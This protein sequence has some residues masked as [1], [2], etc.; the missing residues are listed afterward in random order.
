MYTPGKD[1]AGEAAIGRM[2]AS[3]TRVRTNDALLSTSL[4]PLREQ[5]RDATDRADRLGCHYADIEDAQN[6]RG[7]DDS[8]YAPL[9]ALD[10]DEVK[11]EQLKEQYSSNTLASAIGEAP[12]RCFEDL[13][14]KLD[15]FLETSGDIFTWLSDDQHN[16]I[17]ELVWE[18]GRLLPDFEFSFFTRYGLALPVGGQVHG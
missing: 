7:G 15:V 13:A 12:I 14:I 6:G 8:F 18:F 1:A 10:L 2:L 11:A 5:W 4:Q 17:V 3:A 9:V 16:P